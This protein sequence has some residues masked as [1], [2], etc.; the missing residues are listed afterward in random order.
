MRVDE[1]RLAKRELA[2]ELRRDVRVAGFGE[3]AFAGA[4]DESRVARGIE[5]SAH[6]ARRDELNRL[7]RMLLLLRLLLV[8]SAAG[9]TALTAT[10]A[11]PVTSAS[12]ASVVESAAATAASSATTA[13]ILP[14]VAVLVLSSSPPPLSPRGEL[15]WFPDQPP[16]APPC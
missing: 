8:L 14:A 3:V 7:R 6:L 5:P 4:A 12:V 9:S 11:A 16:P 13:L 10:A 15:P 2:D 1:V